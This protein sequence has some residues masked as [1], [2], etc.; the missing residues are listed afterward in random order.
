MGFLVAL[1]KEQRVAI[2]Q[3][4]GLRWTLWSV[5]VLAMSARKIQDII[6]KIIAYYTCQILYRALMILYLRFPK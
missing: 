2:P 4:V 6:S 3:F 5:G 1:D